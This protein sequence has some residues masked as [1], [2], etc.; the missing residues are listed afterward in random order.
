MAE[1]KHTF[2][3]TGITVSIRKVSPLLLNELRRRNPEPQPPKNLVDY[4]DGKK[5]LE[6]NRA[7]P[8]YMA[9]LDKHAQELEL[10][11][12]M[13]LIRW[14]VVYELTAQDLEQVKQLKEFWQTEY[15]QELEGTDLEVFISYIAIGTVEDLEE[16]T[17]AIM[18]RSQ[19]TPAAEGEAAQRYKSPVPG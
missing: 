1:N 4:G 7:D 3:D 18:R 13:L 15:Q 16:L 19:P 17:N 9:A 12:R 10:K 5:V 14:G 6:E 2:Q 8:D 11:M